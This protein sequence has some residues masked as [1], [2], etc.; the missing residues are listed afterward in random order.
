MEISGGK[1]VYLSTYIVMTAF[2]NAAL[3]L[4]CSSIGKNVIGE[5]LKVNGGKGEGGGLRGLKLLEFVGSAFLLP[6]WTNF[7]WEDETWA[8]F[9]TLEAAARVTTCPCVPTKQNGLT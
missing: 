3:S 8:E 7:G 6:R 2:V 9:S 4:P 5:S 1:A